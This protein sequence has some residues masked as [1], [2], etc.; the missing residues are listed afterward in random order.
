VRS[1]EVQ[2]S[3]GRGGETGWL[4][5]W[6][7]EA[8]RGGGGGYMMGWDWRRRGG[9]R[10]NCSLWGL[11]SVRVSLLLGPRAPRPG[12]ACQCLRRAPPL[13]RPCL[14]G[15]TSRAVVVPC[16]VGSGQAR[17]GLEE[18]PPPGRSTTRRVKGPTG[19]RLASPLFVSFRPKCFWERCP[20]RA[21]AGAG[22]AAAARCL[23]SLAHTHRVPAAAGVMCDSDRRT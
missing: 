16:V 23:F 14:R 22:A 20:R 4:L 13:P 10:S 9:G 19:Q 8:R 6:E 5:C 1:G 2:Q 17:W 3:R 11:A 15:L 18:S 21:G 7:R 12:P